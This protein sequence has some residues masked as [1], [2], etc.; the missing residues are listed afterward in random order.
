M[1]SKN[2][3]LVLLDALSSYKN[4]FGVSPTLCGS[5]NMSKHT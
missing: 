3:Q 4:G 2:T 5:Y 1:Y